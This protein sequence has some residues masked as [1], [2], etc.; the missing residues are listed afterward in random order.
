MLNTRIKDVKEYGPLSEEAI[1]YM[2][3][4]IMQAHI[5]GKGKK[6][7]IKDSQPIVE[8]GNPAE[9]AQWK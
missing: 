9:D 1:D 7:T 8:T 3:G 4:C 6:I 2:F 5:L